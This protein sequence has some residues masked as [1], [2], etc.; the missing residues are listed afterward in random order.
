MSVS[1]FANDSQSLNIVKDCSLWM[2]CRCL[3]ENTAILEELITLRQRVRM[4]VTLSYE[5]I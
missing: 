4:I 3:K 5:M 2:L 1:V